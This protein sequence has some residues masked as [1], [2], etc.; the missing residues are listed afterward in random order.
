MVAGRKL[1]VPVSKRV[2]TVPVGRP[3][4]FT[5]ALAGVA[6]RLAA[7]G[8]PTAARA[9]GALRTVQAV[10]QNAESTYTSYLQTVIG[11][12][13][14]AANTKDRPVGTSLGPGGGTQF[15]PWLIG[16]TYATAEDIIAGRGNVVLQPGILP[17]SYRDS[18]AGGIGN[19]TLYVEV[20]RVP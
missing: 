1:L 12:A 20:K 2:P 9:A 19:Y 17:L 18:F 16:I 10:M 13:L 7:L 14:I 8:T 6:Q 15:A 5:M 11:S 4:D 3:N